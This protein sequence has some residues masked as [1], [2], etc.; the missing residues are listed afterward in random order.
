MLNAKLPPG[1]QL[2]PGVRLPSDEDLASA[3]RIV[4]GETLFPDEELPGEHL[5]TDEKPFSDVRLVLWSLVF[6]VLM[7]CSVFVVSHHDSRPSQADAA[8]SIAAVP[9][10][11]AEAAAPAPPLANTVAAIPAPLPV[12]AEPTATAL[13]PAT[14]TPSVPAPPPGTGEAAASIVHPMAPS[15]PP[16]QLVLRPPPRPTHPEKLAQAARWR[17]NEVCPIALAG[18]IGPRCNTFS[19]ARAPIQ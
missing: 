5:L 7:A 12:T 4:P 16:E 8:A 15:P 2:P 13:P 3:E 1:V 17:A 11:T 10:A 18:I 19:R 9:R 14:A 6:V